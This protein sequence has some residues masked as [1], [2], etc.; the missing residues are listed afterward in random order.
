MKKLFINIFLFL[1]III[2]PYYLLDHV[3]TK[4]LRNT[5]FANGCLNDIYNSRV[6]ADLIIVGSSRA[7]VHYNPLIL[8]SILHLNSYNIGLKG[9]RFQL[10]Y[11]VFNIYMAHN[12]KPKYVI[13]NIDP[14]LLEPRE[15]FFEYEQFIPYANDSIIKKYTKGM[16]GAFTVPELY[17][18]LFIYNGHTDF[19]V[20][21]I[22]SY[23]HRSVGKSKKIVIKGFEPNSEIWDGRFE[24]FKKQY[25]NGITI[26]NSDTIKK[27]FED[28]LAYCKSNDIKVIFVVTPVYYEET[29]MVNNLPELMALFNQYAKTY[30]I[31]MLDYSN[32]PLCFDKKYFYNSQHLNAMGADLFS[33]QLARDLKKYIPGN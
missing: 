8:D 18:P 31:P 27:E 28:Y 17:M 20:K 25:P 7:K 19:I 3:V 21:G 9:H 29:K 12:K 16:K 4:G 1:C 5:N 15:D 14:S 11:P 24:I 26:K 23:F 2:P 13:Q 32:I 33:L 22:K 6:N 10:Q 30:N